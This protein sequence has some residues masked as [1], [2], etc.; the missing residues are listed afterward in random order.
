[1]PNA[2]VVVVGGGIIGTTV[3]LELQRRG[4]AVIIVE[5]DAIGAGT[6]GGSAGY[7]AWDDIFPIPNPSVVADL[8]RMLL[9]KRGSLVIRPSYLPHMAGWGL[10]FL[11]AARPSQVQHAMAALVS[12]KRFA[13]EAL[14]DLARH[15]GAQR[16]LV[17]ETVFHVCRTSKT[18]QQAVRDL[19]IVSR[20]GI[21]G[22]VIN[23][24]QLL[25][26]EPALG[27]GLAGAIAIANAVRCTNPGAFGASLAQ[28][29]I[30][31]DGMTH[32]ARA[33]TIES[34]TNGWLV[35]TG[36]PG[37]TLRAGRVV[38]AA[39][40][41]SRPIL[42]ALGYRIPL[43]SARGY[44]LMLPDP[45]IMPQR[46]L[47]F[48][49]EHFVATPMEEGLRLAGTVEFAGVNAPPSNYRADM[50]F[51]IARDYLPALN[52][53]GAVRWMGHRPSLPDS[54]PIIAQLRRHPGIVV[55]TGHERRGLT[56]CGITARC[57]ADLIEQKT[58]PVDLTPFGIERF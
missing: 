16:Y 51:D 10:R 40:V 6:A 32:T 30:A 48:D 57:V 1:M 5:P 49:L 31:H 15:A 9:D 53:N 45:G 19:E 47:R 44:H 27:Q 55:A 43:E 52:R 46:I 42:A 39:G 13:D 11:A 28:H 3:A 50:L 21:T 29:F 35:R 2:D 38:L 8:P 26:S 36:V 25:A 56:E 54:L 17:R 4:Y 33:T 7:I 12:L 22:E 24:S 18:L 23:G 14:F 20:A 58:P 34:D 41:W 37:E